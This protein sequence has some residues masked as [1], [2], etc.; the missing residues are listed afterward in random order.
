MR[1]LTLSLALA[2]VLAVPHALAQADARVTKLAAGAIQTKA[3]G[4]IERRPVAHLP[5]FVEFDRSPALTKGMA[6]ALEAQGIR[7]T[8]D[9]SAAPATLSIC[10][11]LVLM[12]GLVFYKGAK[13]PMGEATERTLA[14]ASTNRTTTAGEAA[15]TAA[16]VALEVA[17]LKA[18][19]TPCWSGLAV[20]RTAEVLG[21]AT[22]IK[23]A[24][25]TALNEDIRGVCLSRC[26]D[27]KK[28]KQS[29]YAFVTFAGPDGKQEVRVLATAFAE[30]VAPEEVV[31]E[32]LSKAL[33]SITLQ[34][35]TA[36]PQ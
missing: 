9:R 5:L 3:N 14:A 16:T 25:N 11:D 19:T 1:R 22:G 24:F 36:E 18:A 30:T 28:V 20:S 7:T 15:N 6:S 10:G 27:W 12:G 21:E 31:A 23:G 8:Q 17:A 35:A 32:T 34:P 2:L 13:V 26:E 29:A 33:G 4:R